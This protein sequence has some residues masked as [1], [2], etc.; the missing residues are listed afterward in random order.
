[1]N[2]YVRQEVLKEIGVSGQKKLSEASVAVIG[3]GALGTVVCE[4]L[5]RA[6]IGNIYLI[7]RDKV[8]LVNLQRQFLFAEA[9]VGK[10]K[11][12]VAKKRLFKINSDVSVIVAKEFLNVQNADSLLADVSLILDCTDN[13]AARTIINDYCELSK[14]K[15]IYSAASGVKGNVLVVDDSNLFRKFFRS[16]ETF[17]RCEE[18][19]V[20]N[21]ITSMV[22][23]LQVT[24]AIKI[25]LG[26]NYCKDLI[27]FNVWSN[28]YEKIKLKK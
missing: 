11:V 13:M 26:K 7:D 27:R 25:I 4:L 28:S 14:K 22:A 18:I 16:G 19:G 1:M 2:R 8:S 20:I 21:T 3:A 9:D 24:E 5:V 17:D 15:W 6:G 12:D 23:G 10:F